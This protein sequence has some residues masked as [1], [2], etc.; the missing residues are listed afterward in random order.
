MPML[1]T[2]FP[3][4]SLSFSANFPS[5]VKSPFW[6]VVEHS[7]LKCTEGAASVFRLN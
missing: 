6:T 3:H 4:I 2:D 1:V 5:H 7:R